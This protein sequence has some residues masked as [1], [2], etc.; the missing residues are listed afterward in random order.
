MKEEKKEGLVEED[1]Y[2]WA[3]YIKA[4]RCTVLNTR[5]KR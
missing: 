2:K 1:E 3:T 5:T 4:K